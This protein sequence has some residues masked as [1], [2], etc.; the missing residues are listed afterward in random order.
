MR[1]KILD[2]RHSGGEIY[3]YVNLKLVN[4]EFFELKKGA[5]FRI[6]P[7]PHLTGRF[8]TM[9]FPERIV[10][11][12]HSGRLGMDDIFNEWKDV[13]IFLEVLATDRFSGGMKFFRSPLYR[14]SDIRNGIFKGKDHDVIIAQSRTRGGRP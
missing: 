8:G 1:L 10:D 7:L 5:M 6:T 4:D 13:A 3:D 14:K 9:V 12:Y 11:R 2:V